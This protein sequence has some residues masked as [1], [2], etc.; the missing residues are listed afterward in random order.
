MYGSG[1]STEGDLADMG[2]ELGMIEKSGTW[3]TLGQERMQGRENLKRF[4]IENPEAMKDLDLRVRK[5]VGLIKDNEKPEESAPAKET[6]KETKSSRA[7]A[8]S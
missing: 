6:A 5:A 1:I 2:I 8:K 7:A 4:L 3:F